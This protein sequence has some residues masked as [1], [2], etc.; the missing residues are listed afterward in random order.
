MGIYLLRFGVLSAGADKVDHGV[1]FSVTDEWV[2]CSAGE[3]KLRPL[4][5]ALMLMLAGFTVY[6][7]CFVILAI[8][9]LHI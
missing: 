1:E 8:E 4:R 9:K 7:K 2:S 3:F 5:H 6:Q